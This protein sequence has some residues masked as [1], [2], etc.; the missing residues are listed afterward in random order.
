MFCSEKWGRSRFDVSRSFC[1]CRRN[2]TVQETDMILYSRVA[3]TCSWRAWTDPS[4]LSD[5]DVQQW[6]S[7]NSHSA[8]HTF[9]QVAVVENKYQRAAFHSYNGCFC[10]CSLTLCDVF[11]RVELQPSLLTV[12]SHHK[13]DCSW[14]CL[15]NLSV[16]ILWHFFLLGVTLIWQT[17]NVEFFICIEKTFKEKNIGAAEWLH[18]FSSLCVLSMSWNV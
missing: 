8:R 4:E 6:W 5:R 15:S 11:L 16:L 13:T 3:E 18:L 1:Q 9:R 2:T 10:C 12:W 7:T 17:V 14:W